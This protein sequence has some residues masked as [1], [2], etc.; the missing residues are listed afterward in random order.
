MLGMDLTW[1]WGLA[2]AG[3]WRLEKAMRNV[4]SLMLLALIAACGSGRDSGKGFALPQGDIVAG[5]AVY[6][7][8]N[9]AACHAIRG[10]DD[11][12]AVAGAKTLKLG[13][14]TTRLP[15]DGYLV[16]AIVNPSHDIR[17]QAGVEST[18]AAGNSRMLNFNEVLSVRQLIDLI[19]YLQSVHEFDTTYS[20]H[21]MP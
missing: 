15:T 9:C 13:G 3:P 21:G 2:E 4:V 10:L 14:K 18:D 17:R 12:M 7:S 8:M 1:D 16:T 20:G 5:K 6:D 11:G 19:E